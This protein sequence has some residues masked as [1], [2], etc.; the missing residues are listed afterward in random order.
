MAVEVAE[1][2]ELV[3]V[4][5]DGRPRQR[6][7]RRHRFLRGPVEQGVETRREGRAP[8]LEQ[9]PAV[10]D[11]GDLRLQPDHRLL[12]PLTGGVAGAGQGLVVLEQRLLLARETEV[13]VDVSEVVVDLLDAGDH[14]APGRVVEVAQRRRLEQRDPAPQRQGAEPGEGLGQGDAVELGADPGLHAAQGLGEA[15]D[16]VGQ[17]RDLGRPLPGRLIA[18]ERLQDRGIALDRRRHV[19]AQVGRGGVEV[20]RVLVRRRLDRGRRRL[21]RRRRCRPLGRVQHRPDRWQY[22]LNCRR[23][24]RLGRGQRRDQ[25]RGGQSSR[26]QPRTSCRHVLVPRIRSRS[27]RPWPIPWRVPTGSGQPRS[28]PS[29]ERGAAGGARDAR[30]RG[31]QNRPRA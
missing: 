10:D 3:A 26:G 24:R 17:R 20:E 4:D 31:A 22:R 12:Q 19:G 16:R 13:G 1:A 2:V 28:P 9:V 8:P 11:P 27:R 21:D 23:R 5:R 6:R 29:A 14:V 25:A 18:C 7:H 15:H 30:P